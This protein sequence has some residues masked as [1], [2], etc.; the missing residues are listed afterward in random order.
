MLNFYCEFSQVFV[1]YIIN[2]N[3]LSMQWRL[4]RC[5]GLSITR[6]SS[7]YKGEKELFGFEKLNSVEQKIL[8]KKHQKPSLFG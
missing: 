2:Y 8:V 4:K 7:D 5:R 3:I 6:S 1:Q